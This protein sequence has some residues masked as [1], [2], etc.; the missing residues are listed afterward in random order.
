M[1]YI[2]IV[3]LSSILEDYWEPVTHLKISKNLGRPPVGIHH[4]KTRCI[5][6]RTRVRVKAGLERHLQHAN[7]GGKI[8]EVIAKYVEVPGRRLRASQVLVFGDFGR[9]IHG[10]KQ[11]F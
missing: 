8:A 1:C 9:L 2:S 5:N 6:G 7:T 4:S 11:L 3:E 10:A